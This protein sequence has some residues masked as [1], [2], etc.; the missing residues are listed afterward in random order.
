MTLY[1]MVVPGWPSTQN[2]GRMPFLPDFAKN[3]HKK[4]PV[5]VIILDSI[6]GKVRR[7]EILKRYPE[8]KYRIWRVPILN[9]RVNLITRLQQWLWAN[10]FVQILKNKNVGVINSHFLEVSFFGSKLAT[11]LQVPHIVTEHSSNFSSAVKHHKRS[12]RVIKTIFTKSQAVIAV[13]PKLANDILQFLGD[14]EI[15]LNIIGNGI[16]E[17]AIDGSLNNLNEIKHEKRFIFVGHLIDR[18]RIMQLI[19][20]FNSI[21]TQNRIV[22]E[23]IG[24]GPLVAQ[25]LTFRKTSRHE[26]RYLGKLEKRQVL[27]RIAQADFLILPSEFESF[28]VVVA[29]AL[30]VGTACLV[31]K[32]GGPEY[33]VREGV[34]GYHFEVDDF[35]TLL[36]LMT[37]AANDTYRFSREKILR[38][39]AKRF[40]WEVVIQKYLD[41]EKNK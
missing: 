18:K 9:I 26:I 17:D 14:T 10:L 11:K 38:E 15:N 22:L 13:G 30:T 24:D 31:S 23:I 32:C 36:K 12:V 6:G 39:N 29:E 37:G 4:R 20:V 8:Q 3:M 7:G 35:A 27:Q 5:L 16:D 33:L 2:P 34:D 19:N 21:D 40:S 41:L 1:V 25:L 28:G